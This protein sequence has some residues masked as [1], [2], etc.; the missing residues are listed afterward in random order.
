MTARI[1][2]GTASWT[3]PSLIRSKAF[4]PRGCNSSEAR[5]RYYATRFPVVEVNSSYYALPSATNAALW[6]ERT[7]STFVFHM[8]A[9]RLLTG[10]QTPLEALPERLRS[11]FAPK[12]G[13]RNVYYRDTPPDV[14]DEAWRLFEA[15][16]R[17]LREASRLGA[18]H[19]QFPPWMVFSRVALEHIQECRARLPGYTLSVEFRHASWFN[20]DHRQ[21]T[22]A[23]ERELQ[24]AHV[25]VDEPQ[26][27][28]NSVPAVWEAT[29]PEL[30]VVR[31]HGR[32]EQTWNARGDAASERF[33][34]DYSD[35]E[36]EGFVASIQALARQVRLLAVVFNN[37]FEDQGQRNATTLMRLLDLHWDGTTLA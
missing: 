31:L 5:L 9:F 13:Q 11:A 24:L 1:L 32:N 28:P 33:N 35:V 3:D 16:V 25:V 4:Y 27:F 37:N 6:A 15:G 21:Q 26:G 8:K 7:P 17:P 18:L 34:Y 10:H 23:F 30:A 19:F 22:L 2:V 20:A 29:N 36:L 12:S 14:R